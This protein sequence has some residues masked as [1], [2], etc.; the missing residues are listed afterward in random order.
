MNILSLD[1]VIESRAQPRFTPAGLQVFEGVLR[2]ESLVREE[3]GVRRLEFECAVVAYGDTAR[4]LQQ[5]ELP[6]AVAV[7][8]Y[9]SPRSRRTQRL[10]VYITEFN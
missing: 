6:A 1:G 8:G 9:I 10:I 7:K 2:H 4:R 5:L 3:G